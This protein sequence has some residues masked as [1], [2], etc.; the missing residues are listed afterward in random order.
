MKKTKRYFYC[1]MILLCCATALVAC[2]GQ[3][4]DSNNLMER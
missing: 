3:L 2:H 4:A 1:S